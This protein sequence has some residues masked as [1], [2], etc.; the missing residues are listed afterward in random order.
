MQKSRHEQSESA[1]VDKTEHTS[2]QSLPKLW[3]LVNFSRL[4]VRQNQKTLCLCWKRREQ[5][6][7]LANWFGNLEASGSW[8]TS[9]NY[10]YSNKDTFNFTSIQRWG[11]PKCPLLLTI[12]YYL[13]WNSFP[14]KSVSHRALDLKVER[15][16]TKWCSWVWSAGPRG[17]RRCLTSCSTML[18]KPGKENQAVVWIDTSGR[19]R[20][21]TAHWADKVGS[22]CSHIM[23]KFES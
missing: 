13:S 11:R 18:G 21:K 2:Q 15:Q 9:R 5:T 6:T 16:F 8:G 10:F 12:L 1:C 4:G 20:G 19:S 22:S 14:L 3:G 7:H 23:D 17:L